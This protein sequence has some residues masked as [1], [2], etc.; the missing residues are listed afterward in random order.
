MSS[1]SNAS[2]ILE[3]AGIKSVIHGPFTF[4]TR[5]QPACRPR[6]LDCVTTGRACGVM[7]GFSQG[8][9]VGLMLAQWMIEGECERDVTMAHRRGPLW[10]HGSRLDTRCPKVIENYQKSLLG[11]SYPERRTARRASTSATTPMYNIFHRHGRSLGSTIRPRS[12]ELLTRK[13]TSRRYRATPTFRRSNA[14]KATA[15][16]V[17]AVRSAVGINEVQNFGK[18]RSHGP[19]TPASL[20][21]HRVM[22][23]RMPRSLVVCP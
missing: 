23:G 5:R 14:F 9:G 1:P 10:R 2:P 17:K 6:A 16:E 4:R 11:F 13:A 22:A 18:Y 21:Q 20:A 19:Q 8:G 3:K 7:A 12:R 15:R